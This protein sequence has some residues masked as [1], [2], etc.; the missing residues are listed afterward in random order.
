MNPANQIPTQPAT[1]FVSGKEHEPVGTSEETLRET[2]AEIEIPQEVEAAG[3]QKISETIEL[4]PDVK[5]L[6]VV[7]SGASL[8]V[9]QTTSIPSVSLPISDQKVLA[10]LHTSLA[11]AFYWLAVWCKKR[12]KRAHI[13][14]KVI[15]GR[16]IR[17]KI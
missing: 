12:L 4:P 1:P 9:S 3:V 14:L 6:G 10:G 7:S 11:N 17:V 16:I 5:K 8:P 15:G 13:A 2:G